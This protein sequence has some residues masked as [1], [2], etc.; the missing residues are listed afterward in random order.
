MTMKTF[1]KKFIDTYKETYEVEKKLL[2]EKQYEQIDSFKVS[3]S[4]GQN[5]DEKKI[6][7]IV[8]K[9]VSLTTTQLS[10]AKTY[11]PI[12]SDSIPQSVYTNRKFN[13]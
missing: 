9:C 2:V 7:E 3:V 1:F 4:M 6:L 8:Q 5:L 10:N 11:M 12:K 13:R